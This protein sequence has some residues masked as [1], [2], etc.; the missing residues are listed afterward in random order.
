MKSNRY[1]QAK[2]ADPAI[3]SPMLLFQRKNTVALLLYMNAHGEMM[4]SLITEAISR[5]TP[6]LLREFQKMGLADCRFDESPRSRHHAK[7]WSL[8]PCGEA[9]ARFFR[10]S[11]SCMN[12]DDSMYGIAEMAEETMAKHR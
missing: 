3:E 1:I 9:V 12:G 6:K 10:A 8:T 4:E 11:E 7:H 2:V 5:E